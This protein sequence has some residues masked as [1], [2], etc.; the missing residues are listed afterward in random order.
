M[1]LKRKRPEIDNFAIKNSLK[2]YILKMSLHILPLRKGVKNFIGGIGG[3]G[4]GGRGGS[5]NLKTA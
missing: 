4:M 1:F 3:G 2:K 5:T